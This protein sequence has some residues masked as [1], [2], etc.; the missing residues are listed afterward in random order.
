MNFTEIVNA[1]AGRLD[2]TS[3]EGLA[4]I[5]T[6]VNAYYKRLT[7]SLGLQPSRRVVVQATATLGVQ[8]LTFTGITKVHHVED[9]SVSPARL[10]AEVSNE[11]IA[12]QAAGT[13]Q[14]TK[15]AI[16]T[17]AAGSV[18]IKMNVVPQ[19]A[20]DL[21]AEGLNR[22]AT[23]AGTDEPS[24][25]EDFHDLLVSAAVYEER[26]KQEKTQLAQLAKAEYEDRA[27]DLRLFIAKTAQQD[28]FQGKR[29]GSPT[30]NI[31]SGGGGGSSTNGAQS[32][33]QTGLITFDRD[34]SAPFAVSSGSAKV[35]N[36]DADLLDGLNSTAFAQVGSVN[37]VPTSPSDATKFLNGATTPAF[38]Q[39]K[40]SDLSTSDVATNNVSSTKHGF[41]PKS[42]A[43]ATQFL[44]GAAT[45]AYAAVKDSD[46]STSDITTNDVSTS[47]H[48]FVPKAPNDAQKFLRGDA[49]WAAP[50]LPVLIATAAFNDGSNHVIGAI[51]NR[52]GLAVITTASNS[53]FIPF[54]ANGGAG[55]AYRW[56]YLDLDTAWVFSS[57]GT[58]SF[59]DGSSA[60]TYTVGFIG[61][62][63][64][65][66]VQRTA[67]TTAYTV[68]VYGF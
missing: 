37:A 51:N 68:T 25:P 40:D 66:E 24:F 1:A 47:K 7:S 59:Q 27:G 2:I 53:S 50:Q 44:N 16:Y 22:A 64:N 52:W 42:P 14:P 26:L 35:T 41:A 43:S 23:L 49:I 48:G 57:N 31:T 10:L 55:V 11:E 60:N 18:T 30:G 46:L 54:F 34:P 45:P 3:A 17:V 20:F 13:S 62:S 6:H 32:Y 33:T 58:F 67:G 5:G 29:P 39:V 28:I 4:R 56:T 8:T 38:A 21:Y 63:G 36:L 12:D 65:L 9:R 15:Y 61:G 19:S